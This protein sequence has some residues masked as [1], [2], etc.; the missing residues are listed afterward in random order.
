MKKE[1]K[2]PLLPDQNPRG[3][4]I[5]LPKFIPKYGNVSLFHHRH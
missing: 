3:E 2:K 1:K 4:F 5:V